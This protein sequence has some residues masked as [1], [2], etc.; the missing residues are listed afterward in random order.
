MASTVT[1][2]SIRSTEAAGFMTNL[3]AA[4]TSATNGWTQIKAV[5]LDTDAPS[6]TVTWNDGTLESDL[7]FLTFSISSS[8]LVV[9]AK[10]KWSTSQTATYW[11]RTYSTASTYFTK[12]ITVLDGTAPKSLTLQMEDYLPGLTLTL[13]STG[14]PLLVLLDSFNTSATTATNKNVY[15]ISPNSETGNFSSTSVLSKPYISLYF[16]YYPAV[17]RAGMC[18]V[19]AVGTDEYTQLVK[20]MTYGNDMTVG[21][22]YINGE[23]VYST[24]LWVCS[25]TE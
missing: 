14:V 20:F 5:T 18:P 25:G 7:D 17:S 23:E 1:I 10:T 6:V 19:T 2:T 9:T 16:N 24:G 3:A 12:A 21:K 4:L 8:K 22:K 15:I 11:S 13:G